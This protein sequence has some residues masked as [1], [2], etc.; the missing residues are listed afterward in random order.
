MFKVEVSALIKSSWSSS[1]S[2]ARAY[3]VLENV[4]LCQYVRRG[5]I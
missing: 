4:V 2:G 1:F 3:S 5:N